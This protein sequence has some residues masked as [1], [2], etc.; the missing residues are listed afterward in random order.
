MV[1]IEETHHRR[2]RHPVQH[3]L[4]AEEDRAVREGCLRTRDDADIVGSSPRRATSSS[5]RA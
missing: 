5:G 4:G 1:E 2:R 3:G